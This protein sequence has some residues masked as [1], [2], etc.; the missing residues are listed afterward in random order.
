VEALP[1]DKRGAEPEPHE[2]V[3]NWIG[4][5][6]DPAKLIEICREIPIAGAKLLIAPI[7]EWD[8]KPAPEIGYGVPERFPLKTICLFSGEGGIGKSTLA[9]QLA[10]AHALEREW[11]GSIPRKGP[12]ICVECEDSM[13]A[14]HW[15]QQVIATH[16]GV[17]QAAIADAG[18]VLVPLAD[19]EES[20]VL[21]T[22]PDKSGIV[23]PTP[24]YNQIY[25]MA[26]D[27]KPV[28]ISI[29]SAA[30]VFAGNENV[31]PEV[32]QFMWLLRR[33]ALVSGGYVLLIAQPSLTGIG[34]TSVSHAGLSGTTQWHNG[35]RGRAV[36][37]TVK[38]EGSDID[39]G[40]REVKFFKNQY[41]RISS[42]CHVRYT[43]GLF[44]PVEGMTMG[45][46][47]RAAKAEE[48][49][50]LLLRKFTM[51]RQV[52]NHLA[53]SNYAP[54]QFSEQTE[55]ADTNRKELKAAM[56]RLLDAGVIEIRDLPGK[57]SRP[58][59]YLAIKGDA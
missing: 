56:Q 5:G 39:T 9:Q 8:D 7:R 53:G 47:E 45:T 50:I 34:D 17:S 43:N 46:A 57:P 48:I 27:I 35:C 40:L 31:R 19:G 54:K 1:P 58:S 49:F 10:V 11:L 59:Y 4:K 14:L 41:G 12:S 28:M 6:G 18:F 3:S 16:Y 36:L 55:A 42:S 13:D 2:D 33:L 23:R 38:T 15:R 29:A 51:Q 30:I 24:L 22:A 52:V 21:A 26:G 20:P 32:Q 37:R 25:E 44:I